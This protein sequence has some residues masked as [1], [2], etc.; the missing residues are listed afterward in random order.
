MTVLLNT[1]KTPVNNL[2]FALCITSSPYE[3]CQPDEAISFVT[4]QAN[5]ALFYAIALESCYAV[6]Q[7]CQSTEDEDEDSEDGKPERFVRTG[8]GPRFAKTSGPGGFWIDDPNQ[9]CDFELTD[10]GD[11]NLAHF[12]VGI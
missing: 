3:A 2:A 10:V 12:W 8:D 7:D 4:L 6:S 5:A 9:G 1:L 11:I